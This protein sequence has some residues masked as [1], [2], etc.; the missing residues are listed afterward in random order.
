M[1]TQRKSAHVD[2]NDVCNVGCSFCTIGRRGDVDPR[3]VIE[4]IARAAADGV[5]RVTFGGGE[6]TLARR[7]PRYLATARD[8][9]IPERELETNG[10]RLAA[11]QTLAKLVGAGLN[12]A[13]VMLPA[14]DQRT[15]QAAT[16]SEVSCEVAWAG[17]KA[18]LEAGIPVRLVVPVCRAN[19]G[20]LAAICERVERDLAGVESLVFRTLR[21]SLPSLAGQVLPGPEPFT[22]AGA[23][24]V[25]AYAV[26]ELEQAVAESLPLDELVPALTQGVVRARALGLKVAIDS[27]GAGLPLCAFANHPEAMSA[28][29]GSPRADGT[30]PGA[31]GGCALIERCGGQ[32]WSDA[33]VHGR[34]VVRPFRVVPHALR[35]NPTREPTLLFSGGSPSLKIDRECEKAEIRV[36]M[37]CNQR[38]TFCFVNREADSASKEALEAAVDEAVARGVASII[39][40]GGEPTLS[41]HLEA[42]V[43][44]SHAAGVECVGIQTNALRLNQDGLA[45]RLVDAGLNHA[46]VSLHAKD[47]ERYK[48]ITGF[49]TPDETVAGARLV[50][51]RGVE[52]SISFVINRANYDHVAET[53]RYIHEH[54]PSA[55]LI[56]SVARETSALPE[57]P[58][59]TTLLPYG[60]AAPAFVEAFEVAKATGLRAISA[61]TCAFPPCVLSDEQLSLYG[62]L[63]AVGKRD[64]DWAEVGD[65]EASAGEAPTHRLFVDACDGCQLRQRCPGIDRSYLERWGAGDFRTIRVPQPELERRVDN[66]ASWRDAWF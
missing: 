47:P 23:G 12:R 13:R 54:L 65:G 18:L 59:D 41:P 62:H 33:T 50:A 63:A 34:Y 56:V 24:A 22:T 21:Y 39:F 9:G 10:L 6:P 37:P 8:A 16:R 66:P 20:S 58:W 44:R 55:L 7:L 38:C 28:L 51:D 52:V 48:T 35:R 49:G 1:A 2:V 30:A 31:C 57:R 27:A 36:L 40:T 25:S 53:V 32:S 15:W 29:T 43:A 60:E 5:H 4:R 26:G 17:A 64:L 45:E 61:G 46:H 19:S 11:P 42:L 14:A 3:Q